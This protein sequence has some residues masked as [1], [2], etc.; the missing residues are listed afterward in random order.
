MQ[1][2][3]VGF[4]RSDMTTKPK[5]E[6]SLAAWSMHR[7][8][9]TGEIDQVGMLKMCHE[10]AIKG[11]ELVNTFFQSPQYGYLRRLRGMADDMGISLLVIMCD[12]EGDMVAAAQIVRRRGRRSRGAI[13][14]P[15]SGWWKS[16][17]PRRPRSDRASLALSQ[18][19]PEWRLNRRQDYDRSAVRAVCHG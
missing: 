2:A 19:T 8:F 10:F 6:L 16:Q 11:F 13:A 4:D 5:L 1:I 12:D 9:Y 17:L 18:G 14:R 3:G 15:F 7:L